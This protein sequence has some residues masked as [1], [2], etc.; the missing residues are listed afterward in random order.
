[1]KA[2]DILS[3]VDHTL[4]KQTATW[5]QMQRVAEEAIRYGTA[6]VM[7]PSCYVARL[8]RIYGARLKVATVVGFPN[9]TASTA[10]KLAETSVFRKAT[11]VT[12]STRNSLPALN[13]YQPN[14]SRPVPSATSGMECGPWS[15]TLRLPT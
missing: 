4:L 5:A 1:M 13:P 9:G 3:H 12:E 6:T 7:V 11:A 8:A 10:A 15:V 14:Q 2:K